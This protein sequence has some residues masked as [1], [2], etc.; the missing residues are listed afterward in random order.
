MTINK[1]SI[2]ISLTLLIFVSY[3]FFNVNEEK[4][5]LKDIYSEYFQIGTI[6]HGSIMGDPQRSLIHFLMRKRN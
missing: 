5:Y 6:W 3:I 2:L 1:L 4:E